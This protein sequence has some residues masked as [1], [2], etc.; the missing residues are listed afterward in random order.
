[1]LI[2]P[3]ADVG[4]LSRGNDSTS[5]QPEKEDNEEVVTADLECAFAVLSLPEYHTAT[6]HISPMWVLQFYG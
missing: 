5:W 3:S 6:Q 1:L 2:A 4:G